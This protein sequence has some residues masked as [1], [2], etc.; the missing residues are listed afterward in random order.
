MLWVKMQRWVL[1]H[2]FVK[3]ALEQGIDIPTSGS[4]RSVPEA[5]ANKIA[6]VAARRHILAWATSW[7]I[8]FQKQKLPDSPRNLTDFLD[9]DA[10]K[11]V[12]MLQHHNT[13]LPTFVCSAAVTR[14]SRCLK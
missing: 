2:P 4:I 11:E 7:R 3:F 13:T 5:G 6:A 12:C 1:R 9:T 8:K 10:G 14:S